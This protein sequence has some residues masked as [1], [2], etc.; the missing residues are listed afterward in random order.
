MDTYCPNLN[1]IP[2]EVFQNFMLPLFHFKEIGTLSMVS[3]I[4]RDMCNGQDVWKII[5]MR[6]LQIKIIDTS[7]HIGNWRKVTCE[8]MD[9]RCCMELST[10]WALKRCLPT[11]L[12]REVKGNLLE[13]SQVRTDG[14]PTSYF[15]PVRLNRNDKEKRRS[16]L[17][18]CIHEYLDYIE[19]E[20]KTYNKGKGLSTINLCKCINHYKFETLGG[21]T[22]CRGKASFKSAVLKKERTL[23]NRIALKKTNE[24]TKKEKEYEKFRAHAEK[25][26]MD[27]DKVEAEENQLVNLVN[28]LDVATK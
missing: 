8:K 20:W 12:P 16:A 3:P 14:Q 25:L 21:P 26:K 17:I 10:S 27:L 6:G 19:Q 7:V 2:E 23:I 13:W 15:L 18:H 1:D 11:C 5:Y 22:K 9:A 24:R 28:K 4:W